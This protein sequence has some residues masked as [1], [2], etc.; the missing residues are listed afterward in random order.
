MWEADNKETTKMAAPLL[1]GRFVNKREKLLR[2]IGS[3]QTER[4]RNR[5]DMDR[6]RES[7]REKW[8]EQERE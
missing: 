3:I 8:R 2:G 6:K 7:G 5:V 4:K 1:R